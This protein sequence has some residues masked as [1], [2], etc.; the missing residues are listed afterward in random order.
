MVV[1]N[2]FYLIN[3]YLY[4]NIDKRANL[5]IKEEEEDRR[6]PLSSLPFFLLSFT[7][8]LHT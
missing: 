2:P 6:F 1:I 4:S 7:V 3:M 5:H 8:N